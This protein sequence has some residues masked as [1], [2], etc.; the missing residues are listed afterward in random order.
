MLIGRRL[1]LAGGGLATLALPSR[2]AVPIEVLSADVRPL[3]IAEGPRRGLVL[4]IVDEALQSLGYAPRFTFLPFADAL[5][6]TR[7]ESG[8][9][10]TPLARSPQREALFAW[11]A[12]IVDVPQAMGTLIGRPVIDLEGARASQR[13]GVVSGGVQEGFLREHGFANLVALGGA[14]ELAQA[15]AE[16]RIDAW[17]STAT[18]ITLQFEAIGQAGRVRV[19]PTIQS[20]PVW[21][22]GNLDTTGIPVRQLA[23]A[24]AALKQSGTIDRIYRSYVPS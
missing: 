22:G 24:V 19:G 2:A 11:I 8:R 18:E 9:L 23:S 7:S 13:I 3:S 12:E 10:M 14:R 6:R 4:D 15:L 1:V 20:A 16:G 17:Y 21:L 5:A